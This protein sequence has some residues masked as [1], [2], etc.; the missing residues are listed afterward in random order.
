MSG[1]DTGSGR[2]KHDLRIARRESGS[3]I[4]DKGDR[5]VVDRQRL[6]GQNRRAKLDRRVP[7]PEHRFGAIR[8][9]VVVSLGV[10]DPVHLA[11]N[12]DPRRGSTDRVVPGGSFGPDP[13]LTVSGAPDWLAVA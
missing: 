9:E 8:V 12:R 4:V 3:R 7:G 13:G 6:G 1:T 2:T 10:V 11:Y 5:L